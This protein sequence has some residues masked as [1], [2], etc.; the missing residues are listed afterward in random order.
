[1]FGWIAG[2]VEKIQFLIILLLDGDRF[3]TNA[4]K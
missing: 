1:M 2:D 4:N 3:K